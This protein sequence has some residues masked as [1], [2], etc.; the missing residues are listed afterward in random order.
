[1]PEFTPQPICP[2]CGYEARDAWEIC[3][4]GDAEGDTEIPCGKCEK[5]FYVAR[6]VTVTYSTE[7]VAP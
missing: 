4:G 7:K 6:H 5:D 3:F 1:M 2:H